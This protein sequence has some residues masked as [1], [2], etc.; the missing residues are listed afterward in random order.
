MNIVHIGGV[1]PVE[2]YLAITAVHNGNQS[3]TMC[4]PHHFFGGSKLFPNE[5]LPRDITVVEGDFAEFACEAG[6]GYEASDNESATISLLVQLPQSPDFTECFNCRVSATE[7]SSCTKMER[8]FNIQFSSSSFGETT[9][10]TH[11][12]TAH[13]SKVKEEFDGYRVSCALAVN[14]VTQW[15][16]SAT[17]TVEP[18]PPP[19]TTPRITPINPRG[20][21]F[22]NQ[23]PN[24]RS[25]EGESGGLSVGAVAGISAGA[26][27][28]VA[29]LA[30]ALIL[31]LLLGRRSRQGKPRR[32]PITNDDDSEK[33][34]KLYINSS[35]I[36]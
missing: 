19:A 7:L 12:L 18:A 29:G 9:P 8:C 27:L 3:S 32:L 26:V 5:T 4:V 22:V 14:G 35:T 17:L 20:T 16:K 1:N 13:W 34:E 33:A 28:I 15:K 23:L 10:F 31:A 25:G 30:V 2:A 11:T 24:I 36:N 6:T 21:P